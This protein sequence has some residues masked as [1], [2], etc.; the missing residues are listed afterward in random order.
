[1][2]THCTEIR[3]LS[4]G[5]AFALLRLPSTVTNIYLLRDNNNSKTVAV[6]VLN[7]IAVS[8][9]YTLYGGRSRLATLVE[10]GVV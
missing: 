9:Y 10:I 3:Y 4:V 2:P 1:M 5:I 8:S 7:F 6:A